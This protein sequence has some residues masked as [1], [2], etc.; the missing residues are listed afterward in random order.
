MDGVAP[1]DAQNASTSRLEN[2]HRT[3]VSHTA[4]THHFLER[5]K[6]IKD[7]D[8]RR[9]RLEMRPGISNSLTGRL[10]EDLSEGLRN[11]LRANTQVCTAP[12]PGSTRSFEADRN[13]LQTHSG[14]RR[15]EMR[16]LRRPVI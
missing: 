2:P 3:R 12:R 15:S 11:Y 13:V 9:T 10:R 7:N 14:A 6:N 4:H 16:F 8:L 5:N 1:V